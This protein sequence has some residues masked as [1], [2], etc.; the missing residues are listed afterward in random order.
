MSPLRKLASCAGPRPSSPRTLPRV[1]APASARPCAAR[2]GVG[3]GAS[4]PD[5]LR[6]RGHGW[7]HSVG[8]DPRPH[9]PPPRLRAATVCPRCSLRPWAGRPSPRVASRP[10]GRRGPARVHLARRLACRVAGSSRR[11]PHVGAPRAVSRGW[12]RP[13]WAVFGGAPPRP[14]RRAISSLCVPGRARWRSASFAPAAPR[15]CAGLGPAACP[16]WRRA[17]PPVAAAGPRLTR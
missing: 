5:L 4:G 2:R 11:C 14:V 15:G 6:A 3:A 10:R 7:C 8:A 13:G 9:P 16:R 1:P 17:G 12:W